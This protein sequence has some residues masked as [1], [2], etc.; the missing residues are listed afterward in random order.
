M[1]LPPDRRHSQANIPA[2]SYERP[3]C[4]ARRVVPVDEPRNL[5]NSALLQTVFDVDARVMEDPVTGA[6]RV[7]PNLHAGAHMR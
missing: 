3:G 6:R 4:A 5:S 2:P 1:P 7:L